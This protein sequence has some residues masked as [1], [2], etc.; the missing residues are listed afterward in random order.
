L[1]GEAE[2]EYALTHAITLLAALEV[3]DQATVDAMTEKLRA[4]EMRTGWGM[5][6]A[7]DAFGDGSVNP[8]ETAYAITTA[9]AI[10]ALLDAGQPVDRGIAEHWRSRLD[11]YS[12]RPSDAVWT[13]NTAAALASALARLG[14][15]EEA[16]AV[17][18][19]LAEDRRFTW[20]YSERHEIVNDLSHYVYILWSAERAREAGVTVAWTTGEAVASLAQYDDVYPSSVEWTPDMERR[21]DSPWEVSGSGMALAFVGQYGGP[22]DQWCERTRDAL[23]TDEQVPRFTAHALF[24]VAVSQSCRA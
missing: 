22:V 1:F 11:W 17:F 9:L 16:Q 5:P 14:Y 4:S 3:D 2:H 19:R 15:V 7:W 20:T 18:D 12:D 10:H 21:R 8:P 24:G 6:W 23:R 13:P